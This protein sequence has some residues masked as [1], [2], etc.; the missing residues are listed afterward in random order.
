VTIRYRSSRPSWSF[1]PP[2]TAPKARTDLPKRVQNPYF[3]SEHYL[4]LQTRKM[5]P[6]TT[7]KPLTQRPLDLLYYSFFFIHL[8]CTVL[9]DCLP[10]W[11]AQAQTT[12]GLS[13][14]YGIL[15]AVVDDYT[16]KT[17]DPFMLATWGLTPR[18]Y[19]FAHMKVF[20]W[21][22]LCVFLSGVRRARD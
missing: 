21:M 14:L 5:A 20:M 7:T 10:L 18:D 9:I 12:P 19:E 22:E 8:V 2:C 17:N 15:K 13:H 4:T 11:P 3:Q 16:K 6:K 1:P